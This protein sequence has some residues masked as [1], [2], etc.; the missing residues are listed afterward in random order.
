[1]FNFPTTMQKVFTDEQLQVSFEE[2]GFVIIDFYSPQQIEELQ[3]LYKT[4]HPIDEMGFFPSTFSRDKNYRIQAD[5]QIR[6]IASKRMQELFV[7]YQEVTGSFIVK[8]PDPKSGMC[9]HQDMSLIDESKFTGINIWSPLIDLTV[10]NGTIFVLPKSHRFFPT[11]R[12]SSI[13]EFFSPVMNEII[14]FLEP[15]LISA[16][17]AVVFD[18]S[19]IHFSPPNFSDQTRIVTN[20][21]ITNQNADFRTYFWDKNKGNK[22]EKFAQ[23]SSFMTDFEQFGE[24]IH[25]R[26][27]VGEHIQDVEYNFPKI[28]KEFLE[29]NCKK[30]NARFLIQEVEKEHLPVQEIASPK[31]SWWQKIWKS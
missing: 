27:T 17:K 21:F 16:G 12:G 1:M 9:V 19:I 18:Q 23:N 26:P 28:N 25:Q 31:L 15:V 22:I 30:T 11:Y 7:N 29:Q 5:I 2:N 6:E 13:P 4:L 3:H 20:I 8:S 24:N 10:E 14:D